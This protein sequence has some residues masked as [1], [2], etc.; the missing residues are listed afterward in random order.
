MAGVELNEVGVGKC[1]RFLQLPYYN[2]V[3][4]NKITR[5]KLARFF[6]RM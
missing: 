5:G 6:K 3:T 4:W 1:L 2:K